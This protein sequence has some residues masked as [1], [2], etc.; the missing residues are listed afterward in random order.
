MVEEFEGISTTSIYLI[1]GMFLILFIWQ[2]KVKYPRITI[3]LTN[4]IKLEILKRNLMK[5]RELER[6]NYNKRKKN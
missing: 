2:C 3:Y 1:C 5:Q 6:L 4:L